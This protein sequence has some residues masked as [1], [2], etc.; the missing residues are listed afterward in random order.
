MNKISNLLTGTARTASDPTPAPAAVPTLAPAAFPAAQ[1]TPKPWNPFAVVHKIHNHPGGPE[2]RH[3]AAKDAMQ[4]FR[5]N[6][7]ETK[8]LECNNLYLTLTGNGTYT[9]QV[10][11]LFPGP[12][13]A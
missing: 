8:C 2:G 12:Y 11:D 3:K 10:C 4:T 7:N 1:T 13:P 9:K 5:D 6:L